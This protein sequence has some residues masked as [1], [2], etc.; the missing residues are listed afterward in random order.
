MAK[1]KLTLSS[2]LKAQVAEILAPLKSPDAWK[3]MKLPFAKSPSAVVLLRGKPGTGKTALAN[4]MAE[5]LKSVPM[6][7]SF[8]GVAGAS[9]G[10][11]EKGIQSKFSVANEME[12]TTIHLEECDAIL[13][14]RDLIDSGNIHQL[15]FVNTML[16][17]IDN[18]VSRAVPS[19]L[20]LST[21]YPK[22]LDAAMTRRITDF[23]DLEPPTGAHAMDMWISKLPACMKSTMNMEQ[24]DK[25]VKLGYTP[26]EMEKSIIK[27]CRRA[28]VAKREPIAADFGI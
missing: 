6:V 22:L 17:E 4:Y 24:M 8:A 1:H 15:G 26:D 23:I 20:I 10:E 27:V 3:G 7:L 25:L 11:T 19:L 16:T 2:E 12:T 21:N 5:Q 18:F 9:L 13:W 14:S 28:L